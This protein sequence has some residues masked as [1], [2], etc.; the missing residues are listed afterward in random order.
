VT[1]LLGL[2]LIFAGYRYN[3]GGGLA[4]GRQWSVAGIDASHGR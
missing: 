4:L 1:E 3:V 2:L